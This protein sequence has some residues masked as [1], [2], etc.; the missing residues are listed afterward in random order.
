MLTIVGFYYA[1]YN[2][3]AAGTSMGQKSRKKAV[4]AA[5]KLPS[6]SN[7]NLSSASEGST[8]VFA[9]P[10]LNN[11]FVSNNHAV[12]ENKFKNIGQISSVKDLFA[13]GLLEGEPI[14]YTFKKYEVSAHLLDFVLPSYSRLL[15]LL[16]LL[17]NVVLCE[18]EDRTPWIHKRQWIPVRLFIMQL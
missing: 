1:D 14:T 5:K 10:I 15:L 8:D 18:R 4:K 9:P 7:I 6:T 3:R 2:C 13:T 17:I 11:I 16:L 12:G